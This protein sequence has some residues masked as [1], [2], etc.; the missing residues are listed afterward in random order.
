MVP[1]WVKERSGLCWWR[2]VRRQQRAEIVLISHGRQAGEH[3]A[4][5]WQA[6]QYIL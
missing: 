2:P 4:E 3:V 6:A 1:F 5:V